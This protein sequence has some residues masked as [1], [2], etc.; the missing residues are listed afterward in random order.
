MVHSHRRCSLHDGLRGSVGKHW[1]RLQRLLCRVHFLLWPSCGSPSALILC[2]T[3]AAQIEALDSVYLRSGRSLNASELVGL[4]NHVVV[5]P[6]YPGY[7]DRTSLL[8]R[9]IA[10]LEAA[11]ADA[12]RQSTLLR[13][14][15]GL[16]CTT[17]VGGLGQLTSVPHVQPRELLMLPVGEDD[18]SACDAVLSSSS[19]DFS[20]LARAQ[21][22]C[23]RV[24]GQRLLY[25]AVLFVR[26]CFVF[27]FLLGLRLHLLYLRVHAS[28]FLL[29]LLGRLQGLLH[30][31]L[32]FIYRLVV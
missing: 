7:A 20:C 30:R 29:Q 4:G 28:S 3:V 22:V 6:L 25:D 27:P 1:Q 26:H 10:T 11:L 5:L 13:K 8:L 17:A 2:E 14:P 15:H 32:F 23:C 21:P 9:G 18:A 12:Y 16:W 24:S 31:S 19:A